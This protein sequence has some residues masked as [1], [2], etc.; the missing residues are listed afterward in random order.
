VT[1]VVTA[2]LTAVWLLAGAAGP[3]GPARWQAA[4]SAATSGAVIASIRIHGNNVTPDAD[5]LALAGVSVGDAFGPAT[6][7]GVEQRLRASRQFDDVRVLER[8][9]SIADPSRIALVIVVDER[10]VSIRQARRPGEA[11][12][13]V[14]RGWLRQVMF[15]PVLDAEDGY[16]LTYGARLAYVDMPR[17]GS[18]F[19]FP[20]TWGGT[21]QAGASFE[22]AFARG[23]IARVQVGSAVEQRRNPAFDL[24][25][26]RT[27][28]WVRAERV[29]GPLRVGG[30]VEWARVTF[31]GDQTPMRSA[32]VDVTFD[33]RL[34]PALP[35]NAVFARASW[36]RTRVGGVSVDRRAIDARGYL[37]L[38]G[39]TVL[40]GRAAREDATGPLPPYLQPLLGG[41]TNL[42]GFRAG[43]FAGDA[44]VSGSIELRIPL[45]SPLGMA[46]MGTSVFVDTGAAHPSGERLADQRF[47]VGVG[48]GVW[49]TAAV[50]HLGVSVAHGRGAGTRVNFGTGLGF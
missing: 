47:Q 10:P 25:D 22:H 41:W 6:L 7:S 30:T 4:G 15:L 39:Q 48:A 28:A 43:A 45:S 19:S 21:R 1:S 8:Y 12:S 32:G 34:D 26:R 20:L 13:V 3:G 31:G 17:K 46:R 27:R 14:R 40:V 16:G 50:F 35:R 42:R 11:P 24:T 49:M 5:I 44:V 9:A 38:I 29:D 33:T 37:G 36:T 2:A 18:R 23:P